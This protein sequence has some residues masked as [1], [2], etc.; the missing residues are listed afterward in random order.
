MQRSFLLTDDDTDDRE[1]FAEALASID[2]TIRCLFAEDGEAALNLLSQQQSEHPDIIFLD[3][4]M[5]VMD[6]W[7][8]LTRLKQNNKFLHIPV[9]MYS[10]SSALRDMKIARDLGALCFI[11]KPND[12]KLVRGMLELVIESLKVHSLPGVCK[13]IQVL[14][15]S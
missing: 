8:V 9:M 13:D 4:N 10:T 11:T 1:L 3:I 7:E 14:L 2:P 6:G 15:K 12:Y 5:P